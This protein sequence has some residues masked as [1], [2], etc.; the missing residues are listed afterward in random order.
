METYIRPV[1]PEN[2]VVHQFAPDHLKGVELTDQAIVVIINRHPNKPYRDKFDGVNY[3]IPGGHIG[4]ITFGAAQHFRE[5]SVV[6]GSRNPE[7][8]KEDHFIA[9]LNIDPP[10]R[11]QPFTDEQ[12]ARIDAMPEALDR[13]ADPSAFQLI[14]AEVAHAAIAGISG[15]AKP[16]QE[17]TDESVRVAPK[18]SE[19]ARMSKT[20]ELRRERG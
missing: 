10:E 6:P 12:A 7:T 18:G 13:S 5:R 19:A 1:L 8:H 4:E 16:V 2:V 9:I 11:C 14:S 3:T 15:T 20:G 17:V